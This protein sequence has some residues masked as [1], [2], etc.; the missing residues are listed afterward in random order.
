M[1]LVPN[2]AILI[3]PFAV[4]SCDM[5]PVDHQIPTEINVERD[6]F[7]PDHSLYQHHD[8]MLGDDEFNEA[9]GMVDLPV[10]ELTD[11]AAEA[12]MQ[13]GQSKKNSTEP[14]K[15]WKQRVFP[16][17][18]WTKVTVFDLSG[19]EPKPSATRPSWTGERVGP[20]RCQKPLRERKIYRLGPDGKLVRSYRRPGSAI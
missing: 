6:A 11:S 7:G 17:A 12:L 16:R 8:I 18:H 4:A 9:F 14:A 15:D 3:L 10:V 13:D 20:N 1:K 5:S 2:L 19:I